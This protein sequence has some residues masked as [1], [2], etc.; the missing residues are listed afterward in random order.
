MDSDQPHT[1]GNASMRPPSEHGGFPEGFLE[2]A[3]YEWGFPGFENRLQAVGGHEL[4]NG[5]ILAGQGFPLCRRS[6]RWGH[7]GVWAELLRATVGAGAG[8]EWG[9]GEQPSV[10]RERP[11]QE[12]LWDLTP[13]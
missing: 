11:G 3:L 12:G 8:V 6:S 5:N 10:R 13:V 7:K 4:Q 9:S 2:E 1:V